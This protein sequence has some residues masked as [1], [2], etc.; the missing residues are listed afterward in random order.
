MVRIEGFNDS[1]ISGGKMEGFPT[2]AANFM[3]SAWRDALKALKSAACF[4]SSLVVKF[5]AST[6]V[7]LATLFL[8]STALSS[9][10]V[11]SRA[12]L[13]ILLLSTAFFK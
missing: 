8:S 1:G 7:L 12:A 13:A 4:S 3:A 10:E 6:V 9:A 5:K 11:A 2:S